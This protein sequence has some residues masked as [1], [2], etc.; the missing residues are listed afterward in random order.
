MR[1]VILLCGGRS[2][3]HEVSLLS[4]ASVIRHLDRSRYRV[5]V[6]GIAKDGETKPAARLRSELGEPGSAATDFPDTEHWIDYLL[7]HRHPDTVV[8]PVLHG[9]YGEDGTVQGVLESLDI[10]YVGASVE[11]SAVGMNKAY[12]KSILQ[13][14][15]IPVLPSRTWNIDQWRGGR[16]GVLEGSEEGL[17]YPVFVKPVSLGSSVGI[18][19]CSSRT[20]LEAA[21]E[22]A[23]LYDDWILVEKG[24][25]AREIEVSVLGGFEA[26]VSLPGEILPSDL[27]YSYEAK[28]L[29][30][31][32]KLLIPAPLEETQVARIQELALRTFQVLQLEGMARVDFL[33]DRRTLEIWVN[34]PNTIPGFTKISMYPKLWEASGLAYSDLLSTLVELAFRRQV[35]RRRLR[36]D[37][38]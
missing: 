25:E 33:V 26:R 13:S 5:S 4:V 28:Y 6:L 1:H 34:E 12:C 22:E 10:P 32:S 15:G 18:S 9:P 24:I 27:F 3:E 21:V 35:R 36:V 20:D 11:G 14:A 7:K 29:S 8:F 30:N 23:F 19:R 17:A 16:T 31:D 2:A 37:R 38:Q